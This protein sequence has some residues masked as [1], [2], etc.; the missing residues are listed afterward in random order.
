MERSREVWER[1]GGRLA[2]RELA[3]LFRAYF[4]N[5]MMVLLMMIEHPEISREVLS[6]ERQKFFLND[7]YHHFLPSRCASKYRRAF[8]WL[9]H[10]LEVFPD[11]TPRRIYQALKMVGWIYEGFGMEPPRRMEAARL[12]REGLGGRRHAEKKTDR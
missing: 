10:F 3:D 5:R 9:F 2:E 12:E 8:E 6:L 1:P 4:N 7:L 11:V